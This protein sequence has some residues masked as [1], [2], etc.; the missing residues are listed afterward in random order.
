MDADYG[1]I[2]GP[3]G[4]RLPFENS[5]FVLATVVSAS[6]PG[7]VMVDAGTKALAVNG[8][9]PDRLISMP[10]G[11]GYTFWGDEHGAIRLPAGATPRRLGA[12]VLIGATHC[13]P[14]VTLHSGYHAAMPDGTLAHWPIVGRY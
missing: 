5:L 11:S 12:R 9:L 3:N 4:E 1:R 7:Q 2:K 10:E 8:P 13:D 14:A 6:R